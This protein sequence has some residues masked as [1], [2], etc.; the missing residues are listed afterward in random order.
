MPRT[1]VEERSKNIAVMDVFSRLIQDR[2]IF[3]NDV[4]DDDLANE[5][6]GQMLHLDGQN[7]KEINVYINSPGGSIL[8]GLAIYDV[9]KLIKSPIRTICVGQAC[10]MAAILMLMGEKRAGLKH[11]RVMLHEAGG[12]MRGKTKDLEVEFKLQKDLQNEVYDI[13]KE[14]TTITAPE[15]I[16]KIDKWYTAKEA[17]DCNILTEIL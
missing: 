8:S 16:F 6:I 4:I 17:L 7:Q 5:V 9:S 1:V 15:D 2:I 12:W 13:V 10:S 14:K 11:S 3:I